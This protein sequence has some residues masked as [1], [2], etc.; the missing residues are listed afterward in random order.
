MNIIGIKYKHAYLLNIKW[1]NQI[2]ESFNLSILCG[3]Y[4][5]EKVNSIYSINKINLN[6]YY[7]NFNKKLPPEM[8][9]IDY[10][11][12]ILNLIVAGSLK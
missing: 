10:K 12:L 11:S 1:S 9:A 5:W 6:F 3:C 8:I 4:F 7:K 2:I